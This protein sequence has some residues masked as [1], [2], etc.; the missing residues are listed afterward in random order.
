VTDAERTALA[1]QQG[2]RMLGPLERH[3]CEEHPRRW[4]TYR[5]T[6]RAG[7]T[8]EDGEPEYVRGCT[9]CYAEERKRNGWDDWMTTRPR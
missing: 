2:T 3:R 4:L 6:W 7:E 8:P 9:Q 5:W 1:T